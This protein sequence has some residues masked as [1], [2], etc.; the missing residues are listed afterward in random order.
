MKDSAT[1][2]PV[3]AKLFANERSQA[4]R[5]PKEFRFEGKAVRVRRVLEGVLLEPVLDSCDRLVAIQ[6][7][8]TRIDALRKGQLFPGR[9]EQP[10]A[11][12]RDPIL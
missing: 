3:R 9:E 5:L 2:S 10:S 1:K 6:E 4:V 11:E 8:L 7:M 12:E